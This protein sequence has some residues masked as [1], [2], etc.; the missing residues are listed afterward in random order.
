VVVS[1]R[2]VLEDT[3]SSSR[4]ELL[5]KLQQGDRLKGTVKNITDYGVFV[6]L[7]GIDGLLHITDI[8]WT[9]IKH[10]SEVL[11]LNDEIDVMVT[12]LNKESQRISLG[13][14]QLEK[15]PWLNITDRYKP[16][17]K[18]QG[19]V[20]NV[21]EYGAFVRMDE[22]LEG[23]VHMGDMVWG[24]KTPNPHHVVKPEQRIETMILDI[25]TTKRRIS[26]GIKQCTE[27]LLER[28]AKKHPEGTEVE[29]EVQDITEFGL[30]VSLPGG[31]EGVVY[32]SDLSWDSNEQA[33]NKYQ[34]GSMVKMKVL[35]VNL[36][37]E[38]IG[39]GIKQLTSDPWMEKHGQFKKGQI[40]KAVVLRTMEQGIE[41]DLGDGLQATIQ[42]A[43]LSRDR[44]LQNTQRFSAGQE[45][46]GKITAFNPE[47]HYIALSIKAM[48][49]DEEKE[50][51]SEYK[52]REKSDDD[53]L[54]SLVKEAIDRGKESESA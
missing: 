10:P 35:S 48:E 42:R 4:Q 22:G 39:L 7:G 16:G 54:G 47:T 23:L 30:L 33:L 17:D 38:M 28:F 21:V 53:S 3:R 15:D 40:V 49:L 12:R 20:S 46:Q 45:V 31:L 2:A 51:L 24:K 29:G 11:K 9:R 44:A 14:K 19:E 25:D 8:S 37:K 50:A 1:R 34:V 52:D 32:Q 5:A 43:E 36:V 41:V 13:M 6:D 26:L 18:V 27:N